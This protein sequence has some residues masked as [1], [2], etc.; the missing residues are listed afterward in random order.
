M[1]QFDWMPG[2]DNSPIDTLLPIKTIGIVMGQLKFCD[3]T[4]HICSHVKKLGPT[5]ES[6]KSHGFGELIV[7]KATGTCSFKETA[8]SSCSIPQGHEIDDGLSH[9]GPFRHNE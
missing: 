3:E 7:L 6:L 4:Q 1:L 8:V 5:R 2:S 9:L